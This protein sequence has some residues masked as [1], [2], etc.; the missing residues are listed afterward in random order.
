MKRILHFLIPILALTISVLI[1]NSSEFF[2]KP[3]SKIDDV[4][5]YIEAAKADIIHG[6]LDEAKLNATN[7]EKAWETV[8]PRIQF[9]S[10]RDKMGDF[11]KS[12]ARL[13][14]S[15]AAGDKE[16][17]LIELSEISYNWENIG[18]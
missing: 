3:R 16:N 1:M 6:R 8:L 14:G 7:L 5:G 12:L 4:S 15:L 18:D 2:R 9:S 11:E 10:E 17:A 13:K